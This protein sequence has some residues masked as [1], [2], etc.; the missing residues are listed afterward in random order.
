MLNRN[1]ASYA[2]RVTTISYFYI[3][4]LLFR[5]EI[6]KDSQIVPSLVLVS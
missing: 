6:E 4:I 2:T 1:N 5:V 3:E